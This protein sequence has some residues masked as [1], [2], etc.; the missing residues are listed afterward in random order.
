MWWLFCLL[1]MDIDKIDRRK[2]LGSTVSASLIG[3]AGCS[4]GPGEDSPTDEDTDTDISEGEVTDTVAQGMLA[5][6]V[7]DQPAAIGDFESLILR[8]EEIV[9]Y[10]ASSEDGITDNSGTEDDEVDDADGDNTDDDVDSDSPTSVDSSTESEEPPTS[11]STEVE[12][13]RRSPI[14]EDKD[15]D[16]EGTGSGEPIRIELDEPAEFDLVEL[17]GDNRAFI[18]EEMLDI[19][20]YS[21]IQLYVTDDVDATLTDGSEA[22]VVTPGNAPLMFKQDFEVRIG[23]RTEFTADFAPHERGKNGY[24]LRPVASETTVSYTEIDSSED[25]SE[26]TES[27]VEGD[28]GS[29]ATETNTEL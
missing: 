29:T 26:S 22:E 5:T 25:E 23:T 3:I 8:V 11:D 21:Q 16:E 15:E 13:G 27:D 6:A 19:G 7:S 12:T 4:T 28:T 24:I 2:F 9:V 17:Q 1:F 14:D 20:E 10:P 18:N